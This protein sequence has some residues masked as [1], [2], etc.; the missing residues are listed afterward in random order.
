MQRLTSNYYL[1]CPPG[2]FVLRDGNFVAKSVDL[3]C[4][5]EYCDQGEALCIYS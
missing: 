3:Y 5:L 2:G 4:V 1:S